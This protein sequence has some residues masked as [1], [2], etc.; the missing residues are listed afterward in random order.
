MTRRRTNLPGLAAW[1]QLSGS[2]Q[3]G[4]NVSGELGRVE[5]F[6]ASSVMAL[7]SAASPCKSLV[8]YQTSHIGSVSANLTIM[9]S[10]SSNFVSLTK[11]QNTSFDPQKL[12]FA[13]YFR[14]FITCLK[15]RGPSNM[16]LLTTKQFRRKQSF[17]QSVVHCPVFASFNS[18]SER[19]CKPVGL[20]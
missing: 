18:S 6:Q 8:F 13:S 14:L 1:P 2:W 5:G 11:Q 20:K 17:L 16:V 9:V 4:S 10:S 12:G 19:S 7:D 3:L 15:V